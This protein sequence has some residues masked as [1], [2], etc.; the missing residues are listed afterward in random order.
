MSVT[1]LATSV[2][3]EPENFAGIS[4]FYPID[5]TSV[6]V[7]VYSNA[8]VFLMHMQFNFLTD[9]RQSFFCFLR[10]VSLF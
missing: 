9:K 2:P 7:L 5:R 4:G 1:F 10:T 6:G 3:S 8:H